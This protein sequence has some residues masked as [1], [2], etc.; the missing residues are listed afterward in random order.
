MFYPVIRII[1]SPCR[2][3]DGGS[4]IEVGLPTGCVCRFRC[5]TH[6][7]SRASVGQLS[8]GG[9][10]RWAA[11]GAQGFAELEGACLSQAPVFTGEDT[12]FQRDDVTRQNPRCLFPAELDEELGLML[13][14]QHLSLGRDKL[15]TT[16]S[17]IL[18]GS[19]VESVFTDPLL[20]PSLALLSRPHRTLAFWGFI[21]FHVC[22]L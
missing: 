6:L 20:R 1:L 2:K 5:E 18:E 22:L 11:C 12:E 9:L 7:F 4:R 8:C 19:R 16:T 3:K 14:S 17:F 21:S 15:N 10:E 13:E